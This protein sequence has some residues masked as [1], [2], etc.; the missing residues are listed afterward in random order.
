MIKKDRKRP[1]NARRKPKLVGGNSSLVISLS[2][3]PFITD[4]A[5]YS[6]PYYAVTPS[7]D[8]HPSPRGCNLIMF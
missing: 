3:K 6:R 4:V 2:W 8:T 7:S 1:P 5:M